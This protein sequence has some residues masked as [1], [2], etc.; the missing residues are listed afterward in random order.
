MRYQSHYIKSSFYLNYHLVIHEMVFLFHFQ[1]NLSTGKLDLFPLSDL[2]SSVIVIPTTFSVFLLFITPL[3]CKKVQ[4]N[5][6]T[7]ALLLLLFLAPPL[8]F[9]INFIPKK[10][11][12]MIC[13]STSSLPLTQTLVKGSLSSVP[14]YFIGTALV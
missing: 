10:L 11:G 4:A 2:S 5:L 3:P 14:V 8:I 6:I 9:S 1:I 12:N 13:T 7:Y